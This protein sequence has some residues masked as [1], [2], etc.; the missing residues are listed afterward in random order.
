MDIYTLIGTF[1][2]RV[3]G[4]SSSR[5]D[6]NH[7]SLVVWE[8]SVFEPFFSDFRWQPTITRTT[9]TY[10]LFRS[11]TIMTVNIC[12]HSL[13][14]FIIHKDLLKWQNSIF[15]NGSFTYFVSISLKIE[16]SH[17]S[18]FVM[19]TSFA[20]STKSNDSAEQQF[21]F[22]SLYHMIFRFSSLERCLYKAIF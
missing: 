10:G 6:H 14:L 9:T 21:S 15:K 8:F 16:M 13:S 5:S 1:T 17:L 2:Q 7:K 19:V 22:I 12:L 3:S 11:K 4:Q 18:W 20:W